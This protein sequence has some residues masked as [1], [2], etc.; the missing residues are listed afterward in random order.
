[1]N[2]PL[3]VPE[4]DG[5]A[6]RHSRDSP[7]GTARFAPLVFPVHRL[8]HGQSLK[9][10]GDVVEGITNVVAQSA[11]S[12]DDHSSDQRSDE[13]IFDRRNGFVIRPKRADG[14]LKHRSHSRNEGRQDLLTIRLDINASQS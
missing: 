3:V 14:I 12:G 9:L 6:L 8:L 1:V 5:C 7:D 4:K 10:T 2:V 13:R 11:D